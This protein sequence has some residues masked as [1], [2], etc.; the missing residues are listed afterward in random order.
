[1]PTIYVSCIHG[2]VLFQIE[3]LDLRPEMVLTVL[4]PTEIAS[5]KDIP[6]EDYI[7][8]SKRRKLQLAYIQHVRHE[9]WRR[10]NSW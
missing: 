10:F 4:H 7:E 6:E 2:S 3:N 8:P 1:M 9:Y 5:L